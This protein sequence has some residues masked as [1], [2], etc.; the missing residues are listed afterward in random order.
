MIYYE[1]LYN[2][3]N[4]E[5]TDM[6]GNNTEFSTRKARV[7]HRQRKRIFFQYLLLW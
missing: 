5:A 7:D 2:D 4:L 6:D 3:I 1:S